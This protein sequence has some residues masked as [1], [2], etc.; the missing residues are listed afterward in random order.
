M[1]YGMGKL[2]IYHIF[3]SHFGVLLYYSTWIPIAT[4]VL[5]L[6]S[7]DVDVVL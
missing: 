2:K 4:T 3:T 6:N 5:N 7:M 1:A